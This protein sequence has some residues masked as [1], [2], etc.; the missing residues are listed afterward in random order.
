MNGESFL[1]GEEEYI[2]GVDFYGGDPVSQLL[3]GW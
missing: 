1:R 3:G 2:H